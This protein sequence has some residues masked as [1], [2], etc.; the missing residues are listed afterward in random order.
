MDGVRDAG[1]VV[2]ERSG[3]EDLHARPEHEPQLRIEARRNAEAALRQAS[4]TGRIRLDP[5][6]EIARVVGA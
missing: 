4:R 5:A 6:Q 1:V 2:V 3:S